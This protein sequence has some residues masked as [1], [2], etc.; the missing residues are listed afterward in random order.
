MVVVAHAAVL[1]AL[2]GCSSSGPGETAA[3]GEAGRPASSPAGESVSASSSP[4]AEPSTGSPSPHEPPRVTGRV[5]VLAVSVDGLNPDVLTRLGR[6]AAP[7]FW[8]LASDGAS[9]L[10]ARTEV[11]QTVTMPNHA[12]M[13]TGRRI[14]ARHGGHGWTDNKD[15]GGTVTDPDGTP[16]PSVF[17]V[18]DV[19]G[20]SSALFANKE[21]FAVFDR[22]WPSIERFVADEDPDALVD[23]LTEDL[24]EA[25]R[26][27]TF[28]HLG[29]P[30]KAGH[31]SGWFSPAYLDA[32]RHTDRLLARVLDTIDSDRYLRRHL[33]LVV[34]ADHGGNG[35]D[36]SNPTDPADYTIPFYVR[37]P[38][39]P[40][41]SDLYDLNPERRDPGDRRP[42]YR[43]PQ[44]VR[45]ADVADLVTALL[46][47]GPVPT[48]QIGA[49]QPLSVHAR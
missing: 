30:D 4:T 10:D 5:L 21:K 47:L 25:R 19:A 6:S 15:T 23:E 49:E 12:G 1:A 45:N 7:T 3:P 31:T 33:T 24:T 35:P 38:G 43:G 46:G 11:E 27:F 28:L 39:V 20:L 40:A 14:A 9:T 2:A 41:G 22:S 26:A 48:S 34:T 16:V 42:G 8:R 36:H 18:V 17:D 29:L 32:V 44:P 13:F 37:G